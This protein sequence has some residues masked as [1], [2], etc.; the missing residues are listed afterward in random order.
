MI[1]EPTDDDRLAQ[2][3]QHEQAEALGEVPGVECITR[4]RRRRTLGVDRSMQRGEPPRAPRATSPCTSAPT[5]SIGPVSTMLTEYGLSGNVRRP[6]RRADQPDPDHERPSQYASAR[7]QAEAAVRL[8]QREGHE[9][10]G[11]RDRE[12]PDAAG[13]AGTMSCRLVWIDVPTHSQ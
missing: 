4:S 10:A 7:Q 11:Q 1:D 5:T 8:G 3:D 2:R 6:Q 13:R 12:D 9:D